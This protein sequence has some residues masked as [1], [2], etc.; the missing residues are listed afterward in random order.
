LQDRY[1]PAARERKIME[2]PKIKSVKEKIAEDIPEA[3]LSLI[4]L[5]QEQSEEYDRQ[6]Q[7]MESHTHTSSWTKRPVI[8]LAMVRYLQPVKNRSLLTRLVM[9]LHDREKP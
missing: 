3:I 5:L 6:R 2:S 7:A 9:L 4:K 1:L 8:D